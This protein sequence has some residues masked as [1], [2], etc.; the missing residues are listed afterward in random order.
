[1]HGLGSQMAHRLTASCTHSC[2]GLLMN[3]DWISHL[4][5]I[6]AYITLAFFK[7]NPW[8]KLFL[9]TIVK[10]LFSS[11]SCLL[12]KKTTSSSNIRT[13][14]NMG[15]DGIREATV[16]DCSWQ[17]AILFG[18]PLHIAFWAALPS[19]YNGIANPTWNC[20]FM[21]FSVYILLEQFILGRK[22][23]TVVSSASLNQVSTGKVVAGVA[24]GSAIN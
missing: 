8:F 3:S 20:A 17:E 4:H 23:G 19:F 16:S 1:M 2:V 14:L 11:S 12:T 13:S 9:G 18:C 22:D 15:E 21:V 6:I 24:K 7:V 5:T 10:L